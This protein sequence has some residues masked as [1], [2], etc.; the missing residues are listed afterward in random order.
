MSSK[1]LNFFV[2]ALLL[3]WPWQTQYFLYQGVNEYLST[4]VYFSDFI[5]V[6][7]ILLLVF[8]VRRAFEPKELVKYFSIGLVPV[9]LLAVA[10]FVWQTTWSTKWLGLAKHDPA[11]LG[12]VVI[13]TANGERWLRAYGSFGHPNIL[14]GVMAVALLLIIISQ[15]KLRRW[16]QY[17]YLSIFSAALFFSFSRAAWLALAVALAV[18]YFGRLGDWKNSLRKILPILVVFIILSA[19]N[20]GLL[21]A[22]GTVTGRLESKSISERASYYA[23]ARDL[24]LGQPLVGVGFHNYVPVLM[25]LRPGR[26]VWSYQPVHNVFVLVIVELGLLRVVLLFGLLW[27]ALREL[28]KGQRV[29]I[30]PESLAL[31]SLLFTLCLFDHWLWSLHSGLLFSGLILGIVIIL[32]KENN[33]IY[34]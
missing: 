29:K 19:L 24:F 1:L 28:N 8:K 30:N 10:Q 16:A 3:L 31:L 17:L 6:S 34:E 2:V 4:S 9:A 22:R 23:E 7:I 32:M 18:Y 27:L 12:Q 5:I 11:V 21:L 15:S 25:N 26:P 33:T 14:G 20:S 13:E